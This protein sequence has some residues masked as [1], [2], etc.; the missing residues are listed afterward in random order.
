MFEIRV[1]SEDRGPIG[2]DATSLGRVVTDVL[3][4]RVIYHMWI[5]DR[6]KQGI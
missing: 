1:H 3:N 4:K 2:Y 5:A 6:M